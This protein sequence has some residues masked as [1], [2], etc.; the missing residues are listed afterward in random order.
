LQRIFDNQYYLVF[1]AAPKE[2]AGLQRVKISTEEPDVEIAAADNV[3]V[4][5]AE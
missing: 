3:W 5:A 1:E 2:K 4:P